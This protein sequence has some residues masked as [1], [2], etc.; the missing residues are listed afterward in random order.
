M[1]YPSIRKC[2]IC[3]APGHTKTTCR[4]NAVLASRTVVEKHDGE[5]NSFTKM[6]H[7]FEFANICMLKSTDVDVM[8]I[9][10]L[11][12]SDGCLTECL[13]KAGFHPS[14]LH[15]CNWDRKVTN[16]LREKFPAVVVEECNIYEIYKTQRWLGVWFDTLETWHE[17][18]KGWDF[19]KIPDFRQS[20]VVAV[21]L[22][23]RGVQ[24]GAETMAANL[25][26]LL[27]DE[28][29]YL[30]HLCYPYD[31]KS[32]I[33]NMVYGVG[34]FEKSK[35]FYL[36]K[37]LDVPVSEF[38]HLSA[39]A[40]PDRNKYFVSDGCY[41]ARVSRIDG[42]EIGIN[43]LNKSGIWFENVEMVPLAMVRKWSVE[44]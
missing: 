2:S 3:R 33:M 7:R 40:W 31:G 39:K 18:A 23:I 35:A 21:T 13:L 4:K 8:D 28:G 17:Y 1:V 29:A 15:A 24:G 44:K 19:D 12:S 22:S 11:E 14:Q 6:T 34:I 36:F 10:Y 37:D 27:C 20:T 42:H 9:L 30:P 5:Y 25:S 41:R 16:K 38:S 32:G 26:K 43:Y